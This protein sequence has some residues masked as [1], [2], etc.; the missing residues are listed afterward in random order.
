MDC[1]LASWVMSF[2]VRSGSLGN[3]TENSFSWASAT[4]DGLGRADPKKTMVFST[5][6]CLSRA[7]GS[8][9]SQSTRM[10][11]AS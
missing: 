1:N 5:P 10:E 2:G 9:S 4:V 7:S 8:K 3:F 6:C 11:R